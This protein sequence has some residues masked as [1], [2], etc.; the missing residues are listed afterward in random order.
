MSNSA[1][2]AMFA[3]PSTPVRVT[4]SCGWA[5]SSSAASRAEW[6]SSLIAAPRPPLTMVATRACIVPVCGSLR[7]ILDFRSSDVNRSRWAI[8]I[9]DLPSIKTPVS[10]NAK[11]KRRRI[12][13]WVSALR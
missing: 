12:S 6:S 7:K 3:Y 4:M 13:P 5:D 10:R 8:I 11:W 2:A 9:S 1:R